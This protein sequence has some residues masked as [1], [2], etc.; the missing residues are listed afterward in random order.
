ME[1]LG[2]SRDP[3]HYK[4]ISKEDDE[5]YKLIVDAVRAVLGFAIMLYSKNE[6]QHLRPCVPNY[7][8]LSENTDEQKRR[9]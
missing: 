4:N 5:Q 7:Y 1:A 9:R 3:F 6:D 2:V 8:D